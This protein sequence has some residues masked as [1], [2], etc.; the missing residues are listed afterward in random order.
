MERRDLGGGA[1]AMVPPAMERDGFLAA[2]TERTGGVSEPERFAS[3]NLS[4]SSGD[5]PTRVAA[6]RDKVTSALGVGP[7][8]VGGQ[9][10]GA[11]VADV[12]PGRAG[13]GYRGPDDVIPATDAL[14]T[15]SRGVALA[16][17]TADCVPVV[18]ASA[19]E[20]RLAVV[21]AG[22]RG[23]A[24]GVIQRAAARFSD[25][26][27]VRAAI[28]PCAGGC[29]YEVEEDVVLAVAA[30]LDTGVVST[31]RGSRYLLDLGATIAKVLRGSGIRR[32]DAAG[33]CTIHEEERFFS[34]RRQGP[35]GR[36]FAIAVRRDVDAPRSL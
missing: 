24:A 26:R 29:C 27:S 4:Y 30:G 14:T 28:G 25:P 8:A 16:V 3:L 1:F 35:C 2:F 5:S 32:I 23:T 7:F 36:Q 10:H 31:R 22:W 19:A 21:H 15:R 11:R 33:L 6:N 12:G 13:S 9:V 20:G 17:A 34:H 18:L